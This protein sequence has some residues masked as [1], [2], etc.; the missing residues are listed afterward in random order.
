M[1]GIQWNSF[2][3]NELSKEVNILKY[4]VFT[5]AIYSIDKFVYIH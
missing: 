4:L 2:F 3:L 5:E 1:A